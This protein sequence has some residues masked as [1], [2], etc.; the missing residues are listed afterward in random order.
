MGSIPV[1]V[2]S[3]KLNRFI[4]FSFFAFYSVSAFY[5]ANASLLPLAAAL[6]RIKKSPSRRGAFLRAT[7]RCHTRK[8]K[9]HQAAADGFSELVQAVQRTTPLRSAVV[10]FVSLAGRA[11]VSRQ[12]HVPSSSTL[13]GLIFVDKIWELAIH[14]F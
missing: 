1:G 6:I 4:R 10:D 7:Y 9:I 14:D 2:T 5:A 13:H 3:K 12:A 8:Q 11:L